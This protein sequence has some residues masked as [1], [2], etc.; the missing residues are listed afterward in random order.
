MVKKISAKSFQSK[1]SLSLRI[2]DML[3]NLKYMANDI[4]PRFK[5]KTGSL[6][7]PNMTVS[8]R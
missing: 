6:L 7:L 8:G 4:D 2:K 1:I 5:I 3:L